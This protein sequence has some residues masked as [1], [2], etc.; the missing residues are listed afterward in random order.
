MISYFI[1]MRITC[2]E[3]DTAIPVLMTTI[4]F[5]GH[6]GGREMKL[7]VCTWKFVSSQ[8]ENFKFSWMVL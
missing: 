7:A 2:L 3:L 6:S 5:Q 4:R 8:A 1:I